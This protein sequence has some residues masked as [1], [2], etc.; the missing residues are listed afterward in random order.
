MFVRKLR[1]SN[2]RSEDREVRLPAI[3]APDNPRGQLRANGRRRLLPRP[4]AHDNCQ[5]QKFARLLG[6][7]RDHRLS[8]LKAC[9]FSVASGLN[10]E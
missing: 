4:R 1:P 7:W 2:Q 5:L 8:L 3:A 9:Q 6:S 10:Q